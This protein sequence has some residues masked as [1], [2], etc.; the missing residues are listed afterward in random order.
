M[1]AELPEEIFT[2]QEFD[3][4]DFKLSRSGFRG[5]EYHTEYSLRDRLEGI[6]NFIEGKIHFIVMVVDSNDRYVEPSQSSSRKYLDLLDSLENVSFAF[7]IPFD[8][9]I[10]NIETFEANFHLDKKNGLTS[11]IPVSARAKIRPEL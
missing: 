7:D 11:W 8:R 9:K 3:G 1:P 6:R 5:A 10:H 2:I 4:E